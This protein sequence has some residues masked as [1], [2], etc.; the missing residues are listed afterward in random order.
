MGANVSKQ[1]TDV[2]KKNVTDASVEIMNKTLSY[3]NN[4]ALGSAVQKVTFVGSTICGGVNI[5]QGLIVESRVFNEMSDQQESQLQMT[6]E[7]QMESIINKTLEQ[8]NS[9]FNLAQVNK[10]SLEATTRSEV[11]NDLSTTI[12]KET[13]QVFNNDVS[14]VALQDIEFMDTVVTCIPGGSDG[15]GVTVRQN[16][17][18]INVVKNVMKSEKVDQVI[19]EAIDKLDFTEDTMVT[20][21]NT[22]VSVISDLAGLASAVTAPLIV[23]IVVGGIVLLIGAIFGGLYMTK[24]REAFIAMFT[25][26]KKPAETKFGRRRIKRR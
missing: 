6:L 4:R 16:I 2:F 8:T 22:G 3:S 19:A 1:E 24:G 15:Q 20:A 21:S 9:K 11:Y 14:A 12:A 25:R 26:K 17:N 5:E 7:N 13:Q 18:L 10:N 23:G